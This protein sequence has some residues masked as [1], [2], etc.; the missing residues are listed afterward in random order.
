MKIVLESPLKIDVGRS[1][2]EKNDFFL[3]V[4]DKSSLMCNINFVNF[5]ER[6]LVRRCNELDEN[7]RHVEREVKWI[8]FISDHLSWNCGVVTSERSETRAWMSGENHESDPQRFRESGGAQRRWHPSRSVQSV[9]MTRKQTFELLLLCSFPSP[10]RSEHWRKFQPLDSRASP[11][12][13]QTTIPCLMNTF[14]TVIPAYLL[15]CLIITGRE[16]TLWY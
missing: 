16:R 8:F 15:K 14:S 4:D 9:T 11:S 13:W 2:V 10:R 7:Q 6:S 3:F 12:R 5:Q 1:A